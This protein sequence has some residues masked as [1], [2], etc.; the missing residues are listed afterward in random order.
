MKENDPLT[1]AVYAEEDLATAKAALRA[2]KPPLPG[3]FPGT[4][5]IER[6][7]QAWQ[8]GEMDRSGV[9]IHLVPDEGVDSGPVLAV[10]EIFFQTGESLEAF[11][12]RVH[13]VEHRLLVATLRRLMTGPFPAAS[14]PLVAGP[15]QEAAAKE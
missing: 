13:A 6:A 5:A 4:H 2:R 8:R 1:W 3:A 7:Y 12:A 15:E 10:E 11:E 9:M 14:L